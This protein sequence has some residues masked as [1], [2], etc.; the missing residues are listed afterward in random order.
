MTDDKNSFTTKSTKRTKNN[1]KSNWANSP[2]CALSVP[3]V[4]PALPLP[5]FV[6]SP[7]RASFVLFVVRP[8]HGRVVPWV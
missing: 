6:P 5:S 1:G 3:F 7:R 4:I 8:F 2:V